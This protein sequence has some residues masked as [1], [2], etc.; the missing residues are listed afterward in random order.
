METQREAV[1]LQEQIEKMIQVNVASWKQKDELQLKKIG[2]I[3]A[4]GLNLT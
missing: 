3:W 4:Q 1:A 2:N